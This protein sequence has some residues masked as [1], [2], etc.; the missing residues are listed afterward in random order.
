MQPRRPPQRLA[1]AG[2]TGL[3]GSQVV[4]IATAAGHHVV[5]LSHSTGVDLT[6]PAS[7]AD[8]LAGVD[9][10]I[11]V[12]R[13]PS[14]VEQEAVQFFTTVATNLGRASRSA[15]VR[16]TVVL[17]IVGVEESQDYGWYVA[18]LAHEQA[19][20][21]HA[22][23][24][25]VLRATQFHEF[26]G[27]VLAWSRRGD[28]AEIM[29]MP[30]QPVASAEVARLL[31]EMATGPE[32]GDV[33]LDGPRVENLVDLVGRLADLRGEAVTVH[34]VPAPASMAAGSV[35][36]GPGALIRGETWESWARASAGRRAP[37]PD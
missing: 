5:G 37:E 10:V 24:A 29:D 30:T 1:V 13:S 2:A 9:A 16:R 3:I 21:K 34:P 26:P 31:V 23:G 15:G 33:E 25:R 18:T 20:R 19:T 14:S 7:L 17:S 35:L 12:T 6:E 32:D 4:R 27:Q 22:P 28:R 8:R 11:D 36:P